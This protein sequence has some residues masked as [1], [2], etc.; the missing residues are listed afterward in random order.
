MRAARWLSATSLAVAALAGGGREA[1]AD[2]F[3]LYAQGQAAAVSAAGPGVGLRA[4]AE[5]MLFEAYLDRTEFFKG[6]STTRIIGGLQAS[7][8]LGVVRLSARGGAGYVVDESGGLDGDTSHG[9][10]SGLVA[11]IGG[12][13]EIPFSAI[14]SLGFTLE[15][16]Y[17]AVRDRDADTGT[18]TGTDALALL[19]LKLGV[20]F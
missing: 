3:G 16:E 1:R 18:H 9:T 13:V 5:L 14:V 15:E 12:A 7:L 20:G 10:R 11:R 4:G 2:L 19:Y 6:S 17:F 8:P